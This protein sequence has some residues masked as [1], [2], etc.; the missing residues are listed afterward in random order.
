MR[1]VRSEP[2]YIQM[3]GR[4]TRTIPD[5]ILRDVTPNAYS[6]DCF[7]LV[8][9]VGVTESEKVVPI[10]G[11]DDG[12]HETLTLK[13]LLERMTH[14]QLPDG[15]FKLLASRLA[16]ISSKCTEAQRNEFMDKTHGISMQSL[17]ESFF[18][19]LDP[20]KLPMLP[21]YLDINE[22]NLE[23]K[24]LFAPLANNPEARQYLLILNAGFI[25]TIIPGDDSLISK[26]FT[27]EEA[28]E[29][30]SAFESYCHTHADEIEALRI[31][32]NNTG[33]PLTYPML[34]NLAD[35]LRVANAKF[36]VSQL[37]NCYS[38]LDRSK[39]K[40]RSTVEEKEAL[41]N[42]IQLVRYAL[43]QIDRLDS[44][45]ASANQYFN[46]WYGQI[47]RNITEKQ[48][49]VIK[50]VVKY[51]ASNGSVTIRDIREEDKSQAAQLIRAFGNMKE[52]DDALLSLARFIIY[53]RNVA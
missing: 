27:I 31:L 3:K 7:Y 15:Y 1:D 34:K 52:A 45:C 4:G 9:A 20:D 32:Y 18:N 29:T 24:G 36:N 2:L 17:S 6:K 30:A 19:A 12:P 47:Q 14:G 25:K 44:L 42:I 16:R 35:Q 33:E 53:H 51:I 26:G 37:W 41:T 49:E 10:P 50:Q 28:Q 8:D 46:L 23:R 11:E 40:P 21:P 5:D 13:Q 48:L 43:G 22:P 38:L 39:V